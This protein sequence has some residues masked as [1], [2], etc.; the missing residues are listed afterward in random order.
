MT[1]DSTVG[2]LLN[3]EQSEE[4]MDTFK[5]VAVV[6]STVGQHALPLVSPF[7]GRLGAPLTAIAGTAL[8]AM[9]I[10]CAE[11]AMD[12]TVLSL[13]SARKVAAGAMERAIL[14][15]AS[16]QADLNMEDNAVNK[17][18]RS[19]MENTYTNLAPDVKY[20][21]PKLVPGL[22][23][24]ASR[25]NVKKNFWNQEEKQFCRPPPKPLTINGEESSIESNDF[26]DGMMQPTRPLEGEEAFFDCFGDMLQTA[27]QVEKPLLHEGTNA[28]LAILSKALADSNTDTESSIDSNETEAAELLAKRAIMGE[29][30]LQAVMK[31]TKAE[32]TPLYLV[33][34]DG[35]ILEEG[36]FDF[37][38]TAAQK[39]GT[40]ITDITPFVI[41]TAVPVV[42][43]ALSKPATESAITKPLL[44]TFQPTLRTR[45]SILS[46]VND[47][48]LQS[49]YEVATL[50]SRAEQLST[51]GDTIQVLRSV[52]SNE[53]LPVFQEL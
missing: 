30:A 1:G 16:L 26:V 36:F 4:F 48:T 49:P 52:D 43:G 41:N 24:S 5:K 37:V 29:A 42:I 47:G 13:S 6:L 9:A 10:A 38:K 20:I 22:L 7:G 32:L 35:Y 11:S 12:E 2:S 45:R 19:D 46:M 39:I 51:H 18:I 21:A 28:G 8:G 23:N 33:N 53:D 15:E 3:G 14:A 34:D 50:Q 40:V 17:K 44:N 25:I 27:F 31:L